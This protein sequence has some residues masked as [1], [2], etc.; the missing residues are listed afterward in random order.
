MNSLGRLER[1]AAQ[2]LGE[3]SLARLL[4][5]YGFGQAEQAAVRAFSRIVDVDALT[6]ALLER[7]N[8]GDT[9]SDGAIEPALRHFCAELASLP[10]WNFSTAW[11]NRLMARW[12]DCYLAGAVAEFP[13]IAI[14]NLVELCQQRLFGERE[15]VYRLEMDILSAVVRLGWC[16]GGLLSEVSIDQ[17]QAFRLFAEDGDPVLG[18]PNRR[19]FLALLEQHLRG[20][21]LTELGLVVIEVDWGRS[22]AVLP[23]DERDG[24]RL[25]FTEAMHATLRP[26]DVLCALGENEWGVILPDLQS[27][28]QVSLA[29][30]KIVDACEV[31]RNN[32]FPSLNGRFCAGGAW[33]PDHLADPLGLEQAARAALMVA[34]GSGRL[35]DVYCAD[36]AERAQADAELETDVVRAFEARQFELF[37][38]PQ[39]SLPSRRLV[40]AEALLRWRREDGSTVGPDKILSILE[41]V[42]LMPALSRW[43]IQRAVQVVASLMA[44]GCETRVSVNLVAEDLKD[45]E[46]HLFVRQTCETWRVPTELLC[47]EITEG[48]LVS[49]EGLSANTLSNL[50]ALGGRLSL[51]DFGTGYSSMDYLRRMPVQE[52]KV[53]KSFVQRVTQRDS[54]RAIVELM[55][56]IAHTF[57]LEV[58]AEGVEDTNTED[59]LVALG[60]DCAQGYLYSKVVPLDEFIVWWKA[61]GG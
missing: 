20:G 15:M 39:V 54:D 9:A 16:L 58:V 13:F 57:G 17:E 52:L 43:V 53:D 8:L 31:L 35:F 28:A 1:S 5:R 41:R 61:A 55:I 50:R 12:S 38:Q 14:E 45:P 26:N 49:S 6:V 37:L 11:P 36:L 21:A 23:M 47:F 3:D 27:P 18:I 40:G 51:D 59:A 22:V 32:S 33:A 10:Q 42:G 19:R 46:L 48:G 29:G 30:H 24:L 44:A 56:R 60:C 25:A 34:K 4:I 7:L 2:A